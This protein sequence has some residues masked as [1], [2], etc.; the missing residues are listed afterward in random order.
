MVRET[1]E[2]PYFEKGF[3]ERAE[4][5][6]Y[7][8]QLKRKY[9]IL[10]SLFYYYNMSIH[11][12]AQVTDV[13]EGTVKSRLYRAKKLLKKIITSKKY[14]CYDREGISIERPVL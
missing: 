3:C 7:V 5:W 4:I 14:N 9:M 6:E 1:P 2:Q 11:E 8:I 12:I 13:P 10:I